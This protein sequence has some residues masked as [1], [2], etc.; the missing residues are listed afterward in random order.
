MSNIKEKTIINF[1]KNK[2]LHGK[3]KQ[4]FSTWLISKENFPS[5]NNVNTTNQKSQQMYSGG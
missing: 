5:L 1:K 3:R 4:Q 2:E